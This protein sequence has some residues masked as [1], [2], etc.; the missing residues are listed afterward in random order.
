MRTPDLGDALRS[1]RDRLSP[2]AVGMPAYGQR[3]A[4]GLRREELASLA[5]LSVDYVTRLE[6]GRATNPSTQVL[7]ALSRAL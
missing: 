3:R 7:G 6:Q 1:W 5:G 4:A 2:D